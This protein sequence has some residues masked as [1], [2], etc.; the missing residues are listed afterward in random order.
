[1]SL[2]MQVGVYR[3]HVYARVCVRVCEVDYI[4]R[5]AGM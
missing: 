3:V 1:M 4:C 5:W 2:Y